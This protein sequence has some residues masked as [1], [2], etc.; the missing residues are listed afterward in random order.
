MGVVDRMD[1]VVKRIEATGALDR[2][3]KPL[4][5]AISR[6]TRPTL[7]KNA[8]LGTWLGHQLHPLLTDIP[9]G[10]WVAAAMLDA[11]GARTDGRAARRLIGLGTLAAVPAAMAGASDWAETYGP[12]QRDGLVHALANLTVASLQAAS[13]LARRRGRKAAG[14]VLSAVS[15]R[16]MTAAAYL[17]GHL[18]YV[19]GVGVNHTAFQEPVTEWT[20]VAA[21]A[22]LSQNKP[23]AAMA[24]GVPVVLVHRND[25]VHA[26][27]ATCVHAGGPLAEGM[28][29]DGSLRCPWHG[30]VFRLCDGKALRGPAATAQPAWQVRLEEGGVLV[31]SAEA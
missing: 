19:R 15:L 7:I 13:W 16:L 25:Q 20:D 3:G 18:A 22:D 24:A 29:I 21:L 12:E 6:V 1:T 17:G 27:S 30:S 8:L 28:L 26:L 11:T 14:T 23:V 5:A 9:I 10:T 4:A 31:R 2:I